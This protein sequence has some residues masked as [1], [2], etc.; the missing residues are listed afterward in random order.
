MDFEKYF[1]S[2]F[3]VVSVDALVERNHCALAR[4]HFVVV[5]VFEYTEEIHLHQLTYWDFT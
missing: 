4:G 1:F 5:V 3:L 2:D